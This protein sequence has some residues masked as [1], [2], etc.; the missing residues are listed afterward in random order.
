MRISDW[1]SDVCSSD[2][3][4]AHVEGVVLHTA[5]DAEGAFDPAQRAV[6]GH[7]FVRVLARLHAVD[8]DAVG[9][10]DLS[11]KEDYIARQL[12]TWRSEERRVGKEGVR[13]CR[14]R[15]SALH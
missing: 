10:G 8:P 9:L 15:G 2:L 13:T 11:R 4:M 5:A 6:I 1:S 12:K 14:S 3:V 7:D